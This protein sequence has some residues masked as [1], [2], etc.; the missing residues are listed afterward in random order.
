MD[1]A[2]AGAARR[3]GRQPLPPV[4]SRFK[5]HHRSD[6]SF[7]TVLKIVIEK[8]PQDFLA[9]SQG[10]IAVE[11]NSAERAPFTNFLT[12]VPGTQHQ[13][14]FVVVG[15]LW[16]DCFVDRDV[17]VD[18]LL[19]PKAMHQHHWNLQRLRCENFVDCLVLPPGVVARVFEQLAPEAYLVQATTATEFA[20]RTRFHKHVVVIEMARPPFH[21]VSAGRLLI[22]NVAHSLLAKGANDVKWWTSHFD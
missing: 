11:L 12:M 3:P 17:A 14:N 6:V 20:G 21:I 1:Y 4:R 7:G 22:I 16:L 10:R 2:T 9:K 18:V 13:K 19:V 15:V 5:C 8:Q